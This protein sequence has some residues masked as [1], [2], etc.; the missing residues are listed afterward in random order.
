MSFSIFLCELD[1]KFEPSLSVWQ[2]ILS[3]WVEQENYY[4][5]LCT[6]D[7]YYLSLGVGQENY[8][9]SPGVSRGNW[10]WKF[11]P[12]SMNRE[13]IQSVRRARLKSFSPSRSRLFSVSRSGPFSV[14]RSGPFSVSRSWHFSVNTVLKGRKLQYNL[15]LWLE[16]RSSLTQWHW[17]FSVRSTS[18]LSLWVGQVGLEKWVHQQAGDASQHETKVFVPEKII[19]KCKMNLM[20]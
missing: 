13:G 15:S 19:S 2:K 18:Y 14:R 3:L 12:F 8:Y 6:G 9:L 17:P 16:R 4:L 11:Q 1:R 20:I 7:N 10:N 5:T